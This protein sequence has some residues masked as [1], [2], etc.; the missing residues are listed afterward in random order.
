MCTEDENGR[1]A[2]RKKRQKG[3]DGLRKGERNIRTKP[4]ME[5]GSVRRG[6]KEAARFS[7]RKGPILVPERRIMSQKKKKKRKKGM[8]E[9]RKKHISRVR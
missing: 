8:G 2:I 7:G 4:L 9:G 6:V 1:I 3:K 5:R